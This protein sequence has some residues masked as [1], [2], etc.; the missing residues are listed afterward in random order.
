MI[1]AVYARGFV[2]IILAALVLTGCASLQSHNP[3]PGIEIGGVDRAKAEADTLA[4]WQA[5]SAM[6]EAKP[7]MAEF[8]IGTAGAVGGAM[9][10][11]G[12]LSGL[13]VAGLAYDG[14][15]RDEV[16]ERHRRF[17]GAVETCMVSRGYARTAK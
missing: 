3:V 15:N 14:A 6:P 12:A 13:M 5:A 7:S 4:C 8:G 2:T 1:A 17:M 10:G 16:L 11:I 9:V